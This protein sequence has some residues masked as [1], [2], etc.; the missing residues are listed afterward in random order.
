MTDREYT[1]Y[2]RWQRQR[3]RKRKVRRAAD[4]A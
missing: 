3:E 1:D 2:N 4:A